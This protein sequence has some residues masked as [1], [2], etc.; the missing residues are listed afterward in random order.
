MIGVKVEEPD[1]EIAVER[2]KCAQ[3]RS[4][5]PRS[6]VGPEGS[7]ILGNEIDFADAAPD[8]SAYFSDDVLLFP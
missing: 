7:G 4:Q 1:P 5:F 6:P 8:K 2:G 3:Q